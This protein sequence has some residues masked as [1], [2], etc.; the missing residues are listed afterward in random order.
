MTFTLIRKLLRDC[1]LG[2]LVTALL[3]AAFQCLWAKVTSRILSDL[4]P[5]FT[6]LASLAG[7]NIGDV[8]DEV[9]ERA[10]Q[11]HPHHHRRRAA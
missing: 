10:G 5:Y 9:F 8:Q 3:L 2:L 1:R 6:Q 4:S 7:Q 11:D